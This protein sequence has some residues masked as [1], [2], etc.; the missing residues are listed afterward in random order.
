MNRDDSLV[1]STDGS[2]GRVCPVCGK[3]DCGCGNIQPVEPGSVVLG[4]RLEKKGRGGK[5]VTLIE[6]LPHNPD[7]AQALLKRLKKKLGCGGTLKKDVVEMQGDRR[8]DV[9]TLLKAEGFR[10]R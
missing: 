9:E 7:Y 3:K 6:G 4:I 1:F 8:T 10:I 5:S 2:H